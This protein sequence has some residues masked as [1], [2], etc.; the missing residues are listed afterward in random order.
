MNDIGMEKH[1]LT[2]L[3]WACIN[4][5]IKATMNNNYTQARNILRNLSGKTLV[6]LD[7]KLQLLRYII[8]GLLFEKF[9]PKQDALQEENKQV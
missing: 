1:E 2:E 5:A 9:G 6:V 3:E 8:K 4:D 7:T